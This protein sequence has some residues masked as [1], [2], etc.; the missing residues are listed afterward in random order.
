MKIEV[1]YCK[2]NDYIANFFLLLFLS[3]FVILSNEVISTQEFRIN[4]QPALAHVAARKL[5]CITQDKKSDNLECGLAE[6]FKEDSR[7]PRQGGRE[8]PAGLN[9]W[10]QKRESIYHGILL[11]THQPIISDSSKSNKIYKRIFNH[12]F[13]I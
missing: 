2:V 9:N 4:F 5:H 13:S 1:V 10:H 11:P 7:V 3:F 8:K 6:V 12:N